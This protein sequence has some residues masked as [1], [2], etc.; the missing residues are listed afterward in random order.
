[1][2]LSEKLVSQFVKATKNDTTNNKKEKTVY[3]KIAKQENGVYYVQIDGASED[4]LIPVSQFT[5]N[6]DTDH[7]VVIL[8]KDHKAVVTGNISNPSVDD[9]QVENKVNEAIAAID[10][11]AIRALWK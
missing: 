2:A 4:S 10:L 1:M 6:V 11:D 5:T 9:T 7:R 8:I 3:G